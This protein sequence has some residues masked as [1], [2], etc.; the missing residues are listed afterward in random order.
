MN[1]LAAAVERLKFAMSVNATG[2]DRITICRNEDLETILAELG[3]GA[4]EPVATVIET[5]G[6]V[7]PFFNA[8]S[9]DMKHGDKLYL[10]PN[11]LPVAGLA[12]LTDSDFLQMYLVMNTA[13]ARSHYDYTTTDKH[14]V[15]VAKAAR[16]FLGK[17]D[18]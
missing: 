8:N 4:G 9:V 14:E 13:W 7:Y 1:N 16:Q 18:V 15:A 5:S 12:E 10:Q 11:P 3:S 17:V 6:G 2:D